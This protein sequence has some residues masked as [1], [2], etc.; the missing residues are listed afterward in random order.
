MEETDERATNENKTRSEQQMENRGASSEWRNRG[1]SSRWR[2]SFRTVMLRQRAL[3]SRHLQLVA[4]RVETEPAKQL[5]QSN[6]PQTTPPP[7]PARPPF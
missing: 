5:S 6:Q 1:A 3:H 4:H 2:D 7:H